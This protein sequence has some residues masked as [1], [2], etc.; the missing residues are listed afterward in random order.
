MSERLFEPTATKMATISSDK[1]AS[2]TDREQHPQVRPPQELPRTSRADTVRGWSE[3]K[4]P[5]ISRDFKIS[6]RSSPHKDASVSTAEEQPLGTNR[7]QHSL[8][9]LKIGRRL[10]D[11]PPSLT[12][13]DEGMPSLYDTTSPSFGRGMMIMIMEN[14]TPPM[15]SNGP[16]GRGEPFDSTQYYTALTSP[17]STP[18]M[19]KKYATMNSGDNFL[20]LMENHL[21]TRRMLTNKLCRN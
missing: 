19:K 10:C 8:M 6:A 5:S 11:D 4:R 9:P 13:E 1:A 16:E 17:R 14:W 12:Q 7:S 3:Q 18:R 15:G 2:A 20:T 21:S